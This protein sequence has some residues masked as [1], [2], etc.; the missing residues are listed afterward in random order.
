MMRAAL[1]LP[2]ALIAAACATHSL[3]PAVDLFDTYWRAVQIDGRALARRPGTR[4]P[5]MV[6]RREGS[7]VTGFAGCNNLTGAYLQVRDLLSFGNLAMTR[8]ACGVEGDAL[9]AAFT[10]ALGSTSSYWIAGDRL[11]LR[12]AQG[13]TRMIL[14]ARKDPTR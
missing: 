12:D 13:V 9:E 1:L 2:V 7:R 3:P 10:R 5:H 4:E 11:E 8:M 14:E 6:L